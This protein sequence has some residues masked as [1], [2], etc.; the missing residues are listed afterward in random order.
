[1][2]LLLEAQEVYPLDG[3]F[4]MPKIKE[5]YMIIQVRT[6]IIKLTVA[7]PYYESK[8]KCRLTKRLSESHDWDL[9]IH[10]RDG[11]DYEHNLEV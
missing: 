1:V 2:A 4:F 5:E 11:V 7:D 9:Q 8:V 6:K 10:L 3:L